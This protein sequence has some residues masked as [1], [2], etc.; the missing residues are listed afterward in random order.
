VR[1]RVRDDVLSPRLDG[2]GGPLTGE[3][4]DTPFCRTYCREMEAQSP[5]L[6][7]RA[8]LHIRRGEPRFARSLR[9]GSRQ[10][11]HWRYSGPMS[12]EAARSHCDLCGDL[13]PPSGPYGTGAIADGLYCSFNCA[14]MS[15]NRY[16]P[17]IAE[18]AER[19]GAC[20][21]RR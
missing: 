21:H 7:L 11:R 5:S 3:L 6:S 14:T 19:E 18:I 1:L 13:I 12:R 10:R 4:G 2:H 17:S 8:P 9:E 16:V 15:T 20:D